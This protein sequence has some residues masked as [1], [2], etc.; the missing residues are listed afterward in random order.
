M[1]LRLGER[2]PTIPNPIEAYESDV[3]AILPILAG[4]R[5]DH[6]ELP[7]PYT[8]WTVLNINN[9]NLS[10]H[11]FVDGM[12]SKGAAALS[13]ESD[14]SAPMPRGGPEAALRAITGSIL[15]KLRSMGLEEIVD[16]P[17][18]PVGAGDFVMFPMADL[19]IHEWDLAKATNQDARLDS[20]LAEV[21]MR[22]VTPAS[23]AGRASGAF[24]AAVLVPTDASFQDRLLGV[25]GRQP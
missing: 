25:S 7:T 24:A 6:L 15:S 17:F 9:H 20:Q 19:F 14:L 23:E 4:V 16:S 3:Q 18:G 22:V 1:D 11:R 2:D 13:S 10:V 21:C 5:S 8:E 12:L